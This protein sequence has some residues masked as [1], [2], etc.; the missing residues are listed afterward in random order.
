M[1]E[2]NRPDWSRAKI[3]RDSS[4]AGLPRQ[5]LLGRQLDQLVDDVLADLALQID[6]GALGLDLQGTEDVDQGSQLLVLRRH[7]SGEGFD[8]A[9]AFVNLL[10]HVLGAGL[11]LGSQ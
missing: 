1:L 4:L 8:L 6:G 5:L 7:D 11:I 3:A 10:G 2:T 9:K